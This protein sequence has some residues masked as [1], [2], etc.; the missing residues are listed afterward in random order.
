MPTAPASLPAAEVAGL[1]TQPAP[2]L[3]V[4]GTPLLQHA[5]TDGGLNMA[6][7][8]HAAHLSLVSD[9]GNLSLHVRVRDGSADVNVSGSMSPLFDS[10]APEVRSV[11]ADQ[12]LG[13]GSFATD[14]QGSQQHSQHGSESA[15]AAPHQTH[16]SP[17]RPIPT[18]GPLA[19]ASEEGRI[20]I[21]A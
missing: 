13:L 12:G 20:H 6:V 11:L 18:P 14:Q 19:N 15:S 21:T 9:D 2:V 5:A 3:P 17:K 16:P 8:P 1:A 10:K 4:E 7:L